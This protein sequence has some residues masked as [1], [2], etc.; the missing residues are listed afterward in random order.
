MISTAKEKLQLRF[1]INKSLDGNITDQE[2]RSFHKLLNDYSDLEEYYI[3]CVQLYYVLSEVNIASE[4]NIINDMML[5]DQAWSDMAVSENSAP[6]I[7]LLKP[8]PEPVSVPI[9]ESKDIKLPPCKK[10]LSKSEIFGFVMSAAAVLFIIFMVKFAPQK[11]FSQEV[12]TLTDLVNVEWGNTGSVRVSGQRLYS[13]GKAISLES[14]I[15]KIKYDNGVDVLVEGPAL[16]E[17][18][19][20]GIYLNYGRLFSKVSKSGI[21][22]SVETPSCK[23]VDLGTEF[24][25]QADINNSAEVHVIKGKVQLYA[26]SGKQDEFTTIVN[27]N[28]AV[29]FDN[30]TKKAH[31]IPVHTEAFVRNVS[32]KSNVIWR[33]QDSLDLA[34]IVGGGNGFGTGSLNT[35]IDNANGRYSTNLNFTGYQVRNIGFFRVSLPFIDGV[36]IPDNIDKP[37]IVSSYGHTFADCP[38]T[39][40]KFRSGI[41]NAGQLHSLFNA[42][43]KMLTLA[44]QVYGTD[45]SPAI[46]MYPN[47]GITFDLAKIRKSLS[48]V[49]IT[50][51]S[52]IC[53]LSDSFLINDEQLA[54]LPE[55]DFW[56]LIDGKVVFSHIGQSPVSEPV[57]LNIDIQRNDHFLSLVIT[58]SSQSVSNSW[59]MFARPML[60]LHSIKSN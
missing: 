22:F 20:S 49:E 33:G 13:S 53:G 45:D 1:L 10:S 48:G 57:T 51:F 40:G 4:L 37:L 9:L 36:F 52:A 26:E 29:K 23:F 35:G 6:R 47:Q 34:D 46:L 43:D 11:N 24:G 16:F 59:S 3:K 28:C 18:V 42:N 56:V 31:D 39:S 15:V 2:I 55:C 14:G 21:G 17:I 25:V 54:K 41:I 19:N 60:N 27:E 8:E 12:A 58:D 44:G 7:E 32:S 38:D 30:Y 50:S 5:D